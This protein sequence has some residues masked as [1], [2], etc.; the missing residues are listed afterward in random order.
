MT[1]N[2]CWMEMLNLDAG[3]FKG[4]RLDNS[5][6]LRFAASNIARTM[7]ALKMIGRSFTMEV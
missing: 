7:S 6:R 5:P 3:Y 2:D 4:L 1:I